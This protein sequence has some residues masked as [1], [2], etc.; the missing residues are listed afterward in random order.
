M[1]KKRI[2]NGFLQGPIYLDDPEM[3]SAGGTLPVGLVVSLNR[4]Y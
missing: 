3:P 4:Q 1:Q 2:T